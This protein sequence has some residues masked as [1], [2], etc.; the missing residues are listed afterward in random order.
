M[1]NVKHKR[2]IAKKMI[3]TVWP[4]NRS[5]K[6]EFGYFFLRYASGAITCALDYEL[7]GN[8]FKV[9]GASAYI[10]KDVVRSYLTERVNDYSSQIE[11]LHLV[12]ILT[13]E[14]ADAVAKANHGTQ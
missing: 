3:S 6:K 1:K 5:R 2:R 13:D 8:A 9:K 12:D 4:I 11:L 7:N 14:L 10:L